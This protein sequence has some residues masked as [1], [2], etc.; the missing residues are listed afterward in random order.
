V[1]GNDLDVVSTGGDGAL[2]GINF[3]EQLA[4]GLDKTARTDPAR[5]RVRVAQA[6]RCKL[7]LSSSEKGLLPPAVA[8]EPVLEVTRADLELRTSALVER[9]VLLAQDVLKAAG[10]SAESL[11]ALVLSGGMAQLPHLRRAVETAF[12]K[13]S[14]A[15]TDVASGPALGAALL[16]AALSAPAVSGRARS[17]VVEVLGVP[18]EAVAPEFGHQ[19]AFERNTRLPA[20][21]TLPLTLA[22]N[23]P[24]EVQ[25]FQG[26][27]RA[28][29]PR[30]FLGLLQSPG[31]ERSGE[32]ALHLGLSA[33]GILSAAVT[34]P[35]G[36]RRPLS[37][38][39]APAPEESEAVDASMED[40]DT[41]ARL[42]GGLKR[43]FSKK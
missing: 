25:L 18:L 27:A 16:G 9:S 38:Q 2:G 17:N 8:G 19:R 12:G 1:S 28:P 36:K 22:A 5:L 31:V 24:L 7:T 43:L 14:A 15:D 23:Q 34:P 20:E 10:L 37:L 21:K 13:T 40:T 4:L 11:D 41:G 32:W 26:M 33:D 39:A 30:S 3:D 35:G 6:E 29:D 42:L